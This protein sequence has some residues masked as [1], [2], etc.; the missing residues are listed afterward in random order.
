M[1]WWPFHRRKR[2]PNGEAARKARQ[3]AARAV[4]EAAKRNVEIQREFN[5]F[6][7]EVEAAM[8]RRRHQ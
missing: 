1:R 3:E 2:S 8:V 6:A 4:G 5:R 7:A